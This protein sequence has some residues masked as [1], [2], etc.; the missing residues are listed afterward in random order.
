MLP[1]ATWL[2]DSSIARMLHA[3]RASQKLLAEKSLMVGDREDFA[4]LVQM[5]NRCRKVAPGHHSKS[6]ILDTLKPFDRTRLDNRTNNWR[7]VIKERSDGGPG[8]QKQQLL[9]L[10]PVTPTQRL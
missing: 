7:R 6:A 1:R 10:T 8:G 9:L 3:G 5:T 4:L 2:L